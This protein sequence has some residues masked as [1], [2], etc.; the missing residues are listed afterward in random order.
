MNYSTNRN[1][2][3]YEI[4]SSDVIFIVIISCIV[5][6]MWYRDAKMMNK[7]GNSNYFLF[8]NTHAKAFFTKITLVISIISAL[9]S[10]YFYY[11]CNNIMM[12]VL[13]QNI[14]NNTFY[15]LSDTYYKYITYC[16]Y[17]SNLAVFLLP[18]TAIPLWW[19]SYV[20]KIF[21]HGEYYR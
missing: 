1:L 14:S 18:L 17:A 15:S 3:S 21:M 2:P 4:F 6:F 16:H 7:I 20:N 19:D 11:Q 10:I 13:Q 9:L 8:I 5:L 12:I